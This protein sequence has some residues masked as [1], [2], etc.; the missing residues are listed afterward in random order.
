MSDLSL[1]DVILRWLGAGAGLVMAWHLGRVMRL[2]R[3]VKIQ[4]VD[5][6][7]LG[8]MLAVPWLL[9]GSAEPPETAGLTT[10]E[11]T[12]RMHEHKASQMQ[13]H[14]YWLAVALV[15][16]GRYF[17]PVSPAELAHVRAREAVESFNETLAP[18]QP[19]FDP[20][21]KWP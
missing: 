14:G 19:G 5:C 13:H 15:A 1:F 11:I 3:G 2:R 9:L 21:N 16:V 10:S 20:S 4:I 18:S 8:M 12:V 17:W 7:I 6:V